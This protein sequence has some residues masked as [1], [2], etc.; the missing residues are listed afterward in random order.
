VSFVLAVSTESL[1]VLAAILAAAEGTLWLAVAAL[2]AVA[3][4]LVAYV[5]VLVRFD[6]RQL[7]VG[8]GDHWVA[9]GALAI[10]ALACGKAAVAAGA[11]GSLNGMSDSLGTTALALWAAA[12]IWLPALLV[13][14]IV[15]PRLRYDARR[16]STVFPVG[17]YAA[18]SFTVGG[19][20]EIDGMVDFARVWIWIGF[21]VWLVF[22]VGLVRR[23][24]AIW[25][26]ASG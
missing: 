24:F 3:L 10:A 16:W 8:H 21:A 13:C 9:G 25:N 14:E 23:G 1:A 2:V 11:I 17:M 18:C 20:E 15:A 22:L 4:G 26:E 19:V 12:M 7:L 5:F 6:L